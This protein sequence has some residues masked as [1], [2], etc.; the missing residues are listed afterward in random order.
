MGKKIGI[1][2]LKHT[3]EQRYQ[4][5]SVL[6]FLEHRVGSCPYLWTTSKVVGKKENVVTY[7]EKNLRMD[8]DLEDAP[9]SLNQDIWVAFKD[10]QEVIMILFISTN[11]HLRSDEGE[12][13]SMFFS[14]DHVLRHGRTCR[15]E[16]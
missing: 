10:K 12:T 16:C 13:K 9:H 3:W 5:G 2:L 6:T 7:V 11:H 14:V 4:Y 15:P 1:R 8:S